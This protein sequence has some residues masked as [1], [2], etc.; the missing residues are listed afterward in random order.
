MN[1]IAGAPV[2][3]EGYVHYSCRC[4][5]CTTAYRKLGKSPRER[6]MKG[7]TPEHVHGT[8]N[9]YSNYACRCAKCLEA[10]R[11][12]YEYAAAWR[13]ANRKELNFRQRMRRKAESEKQNNRNIK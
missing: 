12:K 11:S 10:C 3:P 4:E 2:G 6:R 13:Q 8:W 5:G 1:H 9:G 7:P